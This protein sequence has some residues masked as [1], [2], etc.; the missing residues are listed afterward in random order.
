M[1]DICIR[2][3]EKMNLQI[4]QENNSPVALHV[5]LHLAMSH[6]CDEKIEKNIFENQVDNLFT[7]HCILV[8]L[9]A[10]LTIAI[11]TFSKTITTTKP[12]SISA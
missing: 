1:T 2:Y 4:P 5:P 11:T 10:Y 12:K 8:N 3:E 9:K 7:M 6:C